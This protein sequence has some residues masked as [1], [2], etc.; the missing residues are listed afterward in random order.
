M[1]ILLR[2]N[3]FFILPRV[4]TAKRWNRN[5][6]N[7]MTYDGIIYGKIKVI[8]VDLNCEISAVYDCCSIITY[9]RFEAMK[10]V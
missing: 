9:P 6:V 5:I 4:Y 8:R 1:D 2:K 3:P 7:F 10:V